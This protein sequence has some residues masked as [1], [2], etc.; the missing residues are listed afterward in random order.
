MASREKNKGGNSQLRG[1]KWNCPSNI[2]KELKNIVN[3]YNGDKKTQG[4]TRSS[5]ILKNNGVISYEQLKGMKNWFD[6]N[7]DQHDE[8]TLNGGKSMKDWV[9]S[10][11]NKATK[12]IENVK[13]AKQHAGEENS[14]IQTHEKNRKIT[15]TF[16]HPK[17]PKV[18]KGNQFKNIMSGKPI[19]EEIE[20]IKELITYKSK[21]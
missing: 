16:S 13:D 20:R 11:L 5:N 12:G 8:Y 19:Y 21:I 14:H 6:S 7:D 18:Y 9:D 15:P 1:K 10:T 4:Y 17:I 2:L 3:N